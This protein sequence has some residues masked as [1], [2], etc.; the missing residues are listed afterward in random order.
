MV[1]QLTVLIL[2][3]I[4]E[5]TMNMRLPKFPLPI[6]VSNANEYLRKLVYEGAGK[7]YG[8]LSEE[9]QN[10][11]E[12]ELKAIESKNVADYF[13]DNGRHLPCR[14]QPA[15]HNFRSWTCIRAR[16]NRELQSRNHTIGPIEARLAF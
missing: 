14:S 12:T 5:L 7:R 2:L 8:L 3:Q 4:K 15:R 6:Y 11:I 9:V 13:P 16:F 1:W 10:R